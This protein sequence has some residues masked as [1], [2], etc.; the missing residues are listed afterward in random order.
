MSNKYE[1][2]R[3]RSDIIRQILEVTKGEGGSG[4]TKTK[5]TYKAVLSYEQLKEYLN[6]LIESELLRYDST[7]HTFKITENGLM[8]LQA[9]NEIDQTLKEHEI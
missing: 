8:F 7:L 3:S 4:A 9:Y 2:C 1:I 6:I 5:L